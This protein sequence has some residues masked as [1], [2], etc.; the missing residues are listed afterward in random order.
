[1]LDEDTEFGHIGANTGG[2]WTQE[3]PGTGHGL[4]SPDDTCKYH[5]LDNLTIFALLDQQYFRN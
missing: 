4:T 5:L 3:A 1:M 2:H